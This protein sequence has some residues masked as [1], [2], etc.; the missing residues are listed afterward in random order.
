MNSQSTKS[1]ISA[2]AALQRCWRAQRAY[3]ASGRS[4]FG[5]MAD[6]LH[7]EIV[8][9]QAASLPYGGEWR[10]HA[11]L[12]SWLG[13]MNAVWSS[14]EVTVPTLIEDDEVVVVQA[15]FEARAR[16]TGK[17]V[18]MPICEIIRFEGGL[19]I[20]WRVFYFDTVAI[21]T[22]LGSSEA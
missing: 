10:G 21:N 7:P 3:I 4:D 18:R 16:E 11:G 20:E 2:M 22:A 12:E 8:L 1:P 15:T 17:V 6:T 14:V 9:F 13:A 19:P 5:P